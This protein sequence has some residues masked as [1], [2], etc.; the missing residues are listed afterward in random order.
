VERGWYLLQHVWVAIEQKGGGF[1]VATPC[2]DMK[3][4]VTLLHLHGAHH[5]HARKGELPI[6]TVVVRLAVQLILC[7]RG[8][9][10]NVGLPSAAAQIQTCAPDKVLHVID[11]ET[12]QVIFLLHHFHQHVL[13][14]GKTE[15]QL[16]A[17]QT[18]LFEK[19][20]K[21]HFFTGQVLYCSWR[22]W[23]PVK[24]ACRTNGIADL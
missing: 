5:V 24:V 14:H 15:A 7:F 2:G 3:K 23:S 4:G 6:P 12:S 17:R 18:T 11:G 16:Q 21:W 22:T 19:H 9:R 20:A 8:A 10:Y 13:P 1:N